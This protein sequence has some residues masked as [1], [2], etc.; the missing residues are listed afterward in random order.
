MH[1]LNVV[2]ERRIL[3]DNVASVLVLDCEPTCMCLFHNGVGGCTEHHH[4]VRQEG[5]SSAGVLQS[6]SHV[7]QWELPPGKC[8]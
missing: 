3:H 8:L 4:V 1:V 6:Q 7:S 5:Q 2:K